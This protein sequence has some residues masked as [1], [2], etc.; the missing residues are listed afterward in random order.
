MSGQQPSD[1]MRERAGERSRVLWVLLEANR[2]LVTTFL[3]IALFASI[4]AGGVLVPDPGL[5]TGDPI[6]TLYQALITSTVTGVTLVLTLSQLVLSQELGAVGDQRERMDGAMSFRQD[7]A[8]VIDTGVSPAEPSAFLRALVTGT[9]DRAAA[10]DDALAA[11]DLDSDAND[12]VT[13]YLDGVIENA[14]SV[15]NQL[16]GA[17]F[18]EFDVVRAALNYNYS[19]KLYEGR[20]IHED[21]ALPDAA[22]SE[23]ES[24]LD[25]LELFGPAREH[26]KTLYFQWELSN[27]S[28]TL[29]YTAVPALSV[30]VTSLLFLDPATF[31]G[32]TGGVS[33]A[34][35]LVAATTTV[36]LL[37]FTIL[38]AYMLRIVTITKRTLSIGPFI[39]RETDR[40]AE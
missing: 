35:V 21:A 8:Q 33:H 3:S 7:V 26:F 14:D 4:V 28:Q 2:W 18:G 37:P 23:L 38:L 5:S 39:L 12:R 24:L 1:T 13:S 11:S 40:S 6:E 19:W 16:E 17:T 34:L 36:S 20:S 15:I 29:L 32:A 27:L 22:V 10:V 30:A 9:R 25:T 31:D